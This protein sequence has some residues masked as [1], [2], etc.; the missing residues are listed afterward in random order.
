MPEKV[1]DVSKSQVDATKETDASKPLET[2]NVMVVKS[3]C[4]EKQLTIEKQEINSE[5]LDREKTLTIQD[6]MTNN[7]GYQLIQKLF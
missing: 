7:R 2:L 6:Y 5:G 4:Q 1:V 3:W